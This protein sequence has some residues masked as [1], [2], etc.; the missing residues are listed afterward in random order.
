[1]RTLKYIV[2]A[3]IAIVVIGLSVANRHTVDVAVAPDF[4]AY[5]FPPSLHFDVPLFLVALACGALGFMVGAAREYLREGRVRARARAARREA[6][7]LKREVHELKARQNIDE[8]DEI[9]SL[10]AR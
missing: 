2:L 9:I 7:E 1:M 4:T 6:G 3:V 10:T 8:D 5:G